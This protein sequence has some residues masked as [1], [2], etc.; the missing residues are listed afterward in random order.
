M[1][2]GGPDHGIVFRLSPGQTS[3]II[4]GKKLILEHEFRASI[5]YL[6]MDKGY[7][8]YETLDICRSKNLEAVVPPKS[9]FKKPWKYNQNIY[10][11]RNEIE[12][13]FHR[14]KNFRRI[15]TRYDKLDVTYSGY[16]TLAL[17]CLLLPSLC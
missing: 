15:A 7:S 17:I 13:L 8:S 3:D 2:A 1:V 9:N 5:E 14:L 16:I 11:Y 4:V 6:A 12:R 10:L